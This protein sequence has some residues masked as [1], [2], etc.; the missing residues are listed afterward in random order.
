MANSIPFSHLHCHFIGSYSDSALLIDPA[1]KKVKELGQPAIALTDHGEIN[2]VYDFHDSCRLYGIKPLFGSELYFVDDAAAT[3]ERNDNERFHLVVLAK[4][5]AGLKNLYAM[6][7][8]AWLNN[9][10]KERRGLVD[11]KLLEKYHNNLILLSGCYFNP[12]AQAVAHKGMAAGEK[13]FSRFKDIFN[14][15]FHIEI[16]RHFVEEEDK[17]NAEVIKLAQKMGTVPVL[18]NDVHYLNADD[19]RA[20]DVVIKTRFEKIADYKAN[21]VHYWLKTNEEMV[22]LGYPVE[23]MEQ[24]SIVVDKCEEI[25]L[26]EEFAKNVIVDE[27]ESLLATDHAAY[28]G[29][30]TYIDKST[31]RQYVESV[32]KNDPDRHEE[33]IAKITGIPRRMEPD[34]DHIVYTPNKPIK[35]IIPLKR[36]LGKIITQWDEVACKKAGAIVLPVCTSDLKYKL[37]QL[38]NKE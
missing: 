27:P 23:Y 21:S 14:D 24:A 12:V 18:T 11:W 25:H 28:L 32:L 38:F 1:I 10:F 37:M 31:A 2:C 29:K 35:E 3:I 20:H 36:S 6:L 8:D 7:S 17:I 22:S 33:I 4:N 34:T 30:I 26:Q 16:A 13:L 9:S 5:L 19:W 15:D